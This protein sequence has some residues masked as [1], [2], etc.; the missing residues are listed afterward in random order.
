[1]EHALNLCFN[2]AVLEPL[3][4]E[5]DDVFAIFDVISDVLFSADSLHSVYRVLVGVEP[6]EL[7]RDH[8]AALHCLDPLLVASEDR[9]WD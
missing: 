5:P 3:G 4:S 8:P 6:E 2:V 1:M 9:V 7:D